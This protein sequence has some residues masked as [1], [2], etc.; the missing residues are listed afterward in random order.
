MELEALERVEITDEFIHK[1]KCRFNKVEINQVDERLTTVE[2]HR[3]MSYLNINGKDK[4]KSSRY[5]ICCL[6]SWK[7]YK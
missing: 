1:F 4:E 7:L 3:T 6:H 2:A 5:N